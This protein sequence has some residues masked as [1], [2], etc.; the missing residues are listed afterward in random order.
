MN[1]YNFYTYND[2]GKFHVV[3]LDSTSDEHAWQSFQFMCEHVFNE[4]RHVDQV[5]VGNVMVYQD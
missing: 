1:T 4:E 3:K 2:E 5:V